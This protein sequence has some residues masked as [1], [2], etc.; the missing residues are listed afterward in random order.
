MRLQGYVIFFVFYLI[1][2]CIKPIERENLLST[3]SFDRVSDLNTLIDLEKNADGNISTHLNDSQILKIAKICIKHTTLLIPPNTSLRFLSNGTLRIEEVDRGEF[4]L[5]WEEVGNTIK[6]NNP[7]RKPNEL[8]S[9]WETAFITFKKVNFIEE[10][11]MELSF[12][13]QN[14]KN[15]NDVKHSE[16]YCSLKQMKTWVK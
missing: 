5:R 9:M 2:G 16:L 3:L 1:T 13:L 4:N 15:Q 14:H 6:I 7:K 12:L 11:E 8:S 10:D